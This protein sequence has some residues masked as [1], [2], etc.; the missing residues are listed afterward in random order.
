MRYDE[1]VGVLSIPPERLTEAANMPVEV[2]RDDR[3]LSRRFAREM[4][5]EIDRNNRTG[6]PTGFILPVGPRGGY[7]ELVR[8]LEKRPRDLSRTTFFFMDEYVGDD[9]RLV[10]EDHPLSFRAFVRENLIGPLGGRFGFSPS[11][12]R[13]PDPDNPSRYAEEMAEAGGIDLALAGVGIDGHVAFNEPRDGMSVDDFARL[14]TR[15]VTLACETRAVNAL[16]EAGG[17]VDLV[18]KRAVTVGMAEILGA[19]R[20]VVFMNHAW[21]RAGVRRLLFGE[22]TA[23]F[24]VSLVRRHR[25]ASVVITRE[26]SLSVLPGDGPEMHTNH[27]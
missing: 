3:A 20:I 2:V 1:V 11:R 21:Q 12:V 8:S 25:G 19:K 22:V 27:A 4:R 18:P 9:G 15:V 17:A 24:P 5:R 13:F 7:G 10:A 14:S 23:K 26:V 16:T 6:R